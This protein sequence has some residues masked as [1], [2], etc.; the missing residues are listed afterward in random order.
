MTSYTF[1]LRLALYTL[2]FLVAST[3]FAAILFNPNWI[4]TQLV[5]GLICVAMAVVIVKHVFK[6]ER[7]LGYFLS[8]MR[9]QEFSTRTP[10]KRV[11]SV[12][13]REMESFRQTMS[14]RTKKIREK[15]ML[16]AVCLNETKKGVC[17]L[18]SSLNV[19]LS[20]TTF[21]SFLQIRTPSHFQH[22]SHR[23]PNNFADLIGELRAS[24][25]ILLDPLETGSHLTET[26]RLGVRRVSIGT[27]AY[28]LLFLSKESESH[29]SANDGSWINFGKI[30]SHEINNGISPVLSLTESM[31]EQL[32]QT[33]QESAYAEALDIIQ[34]RCRALIH[35]TNKYR[36]LVQLPEPVFELLS[37][38]SILSELT[39]FH[40][41]QLKDIHLDISTPEQTATIKGDRNQLMLV[42]TNLLLNSLEAMRMAEEKR[43]SIVVRS[44]ESGYD[45]LFSDT[46]KGIPEE[47]YSSVFVPYF[48]SKPDGSG[49]GL[50]L[51]R[52]ILWKHHA[53]IRLIPVESGCT[54]RLF[55]PKPAFV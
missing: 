22:F 16:L 29:E 36:K 14:D 46:G 47:L 45:V 19:L 11:P 34:D 7:E 21:E 49:I 28:F 4:F 41:V 35:F 13:M 48:S 26:L 17:I 15:E 23:L 37:I 54:F 3:V 50:S 20:N 44:T 2:V 12:L 9:H 30:V 24:A 40:A 38:H 52:Q 27:N 5:V 31:R 53:S 43:I 32:K 1:S 55:F 18:D 51:A 8:L 25:N 33:G 6:T 39:E 10:S 42:F